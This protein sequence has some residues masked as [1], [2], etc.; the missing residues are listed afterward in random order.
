MTKAKKTLQRNIKAVGAGVGASIGVIAIYLIEL[1]GID[2]PPEVETAT[3]ALIT[4]VV[5]WL[6]PANSE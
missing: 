6:T 4:A 2:L 1:F 5:T 3:I